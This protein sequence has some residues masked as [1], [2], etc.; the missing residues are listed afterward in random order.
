M[1]KTELLNSMLSGVISEMGHTD[2]LCIGDAGLPVPKG[3]QRIDLAVSKGIPDFLEVLDAVLAELKV[4]K[5]TIASEMKE[6]NAVMYREL[7]RR[8]PDLEIHEVPH[9]QFKE[10]TQDCRAVVR[11]GECTGFSN[12]ILQSGVT[13]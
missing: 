4:E 7:I 9:A 5:I 1:K 3:V 10:K 6:H 13:F 2:T 12:V 11:T 8:F